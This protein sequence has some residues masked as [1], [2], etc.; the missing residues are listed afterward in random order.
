[1]NNIKNILT[2]NMLESIQA[3]QNFLSNNEQINQFELAV[4]VIIDAY[5]QGKKLYIAG[6]GGSAADA[7][8]L[9]AEFVC[10]FNFERS[11]LP[12][13]ALNVDSSIL[14]AIGNDY[15]F[16]EIF[17]RQIYAKMKK[18]DIFLAITT[19]GNSQNILEAL[20]KCKTMQNTSIVFTGGNGGQAISISDI[21]IIVPHD[22]TA[23]IQE[24]H[25]SLL[26]CLCDCVERELFVKK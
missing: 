13:E 18:G 9:A 2:N 5:K 4:K 14:T 25:I 16:N 6:N 10:R 7:Q 12:A 8:H 22:V 24:V 1:M 17:A 15:G 20:K 19:S 26:H 23:I 11:P 3:K 21:S